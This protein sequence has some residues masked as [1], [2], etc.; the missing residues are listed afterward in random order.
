[1]KQWMKPLLLVVAL[2]CSLSLSARPKQTFEQQVRDRM[3]LATEFMMDKASYNGGFVWNYLPDFSRQWGEMEAKRTMVWIQ[4]PGTPSVGH[5]LLDA[6]HATGDEYYYEQAER[7]AGALIWGQLECGGWNYVFDFAGEN[8]LKEWYAT[9]GRAGWRLEEFQHYYGNA[10]YDDGGTMEAATFLLRIYVEKNDPKYRPALDKVIRFVLES[11][12]PI[13]GW[14]QRYPLRYDHPFQGKADYSSFI[15]LNDDVMPDIIEF[16][17]QCYQSLGMQG[18]KEPVMRA[19]YLMITLQQGAPYAGWA[20]QYT[21]DDLKPAHARSYEPRAINTSTTSRMVMLMLQYYRMTAD[22]RFLTGIPAALKF[23]EGLRLPEEVT[24]RINQRSRR[25]LEPGSFL[26]ARFIHPETG[27]PQYV[28]REGTNVYNGRYV[29]NDNPE[30]TIA[31]YNSFAVINPSQLRKY[32]EMTLALP[33]EELVQNSPFLS[34]ELVPLRE[35]YTRPRRYFGEEG[36]APSEEQIRKIM[37]EQTVEGYWLTP[38]RQTSNPYK[39]CPDHTPCHST[40]FT[41]T[42]VGDEYDTSPYTDED[43]ELCIS[44]RTYIDNLARMIYFLDSKKQK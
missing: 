24:S 2:S 3:R 28:H 27:A 43:P 19:M 34:T 11:Q 6:Y 36:V 7:V 9:V 37:E 40:E 22:S 32:Y 10:T 12:Y 8:S 14:P 42:F 39:T 44:V 5:L 13:G 35:Y 21:I 1:M 25:E 31:H 16:L 18:V 33:R 4:P 29:V 30:G 41:S 26:A 17:T 23:L 38:L 15:T 20:D